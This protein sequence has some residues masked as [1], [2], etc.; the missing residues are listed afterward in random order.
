MQR[1]KRTHH[2]AQ[3]VPGVLERIRT[4]GHKLSEIGSAFKVENLATREKALGIIF[5]RFLRIVTHVIIHGNIERVAHGHTA[6]RNRIIRAVHNG[7]IKS[8]ADIGYN[9]RNM[10]F[11]KR[12]NNSN[13]F[14]ELDLTFRIEKSPEH[15]KREPGAKNFRRNAIDK[16]HTKPNS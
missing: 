8:A 14:I 15:G 11:G 1:I 4:T 16:N 13:V 10:A 7:A 2:R 3:Q 6:K 9:H 12:L 5:E